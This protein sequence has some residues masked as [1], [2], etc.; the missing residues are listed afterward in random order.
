[1]NSR[2]LAMLLAIGLMVAT[3]SLHA[4]SGGGGGSGAGVGIGIGNG[5]GLAPT[6]AVADAWVPLPGVRQQNAAEV[7]LRACKNDARENAAIEKCMAA[8]GYRRAN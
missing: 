8:K 3:H 1:M 7:E 6:H 5:V 4:M 2:M